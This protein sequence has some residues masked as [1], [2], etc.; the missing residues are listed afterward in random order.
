M[1]SNRNVAPEGFHTVTPHLVMQNAAEAIAFYQKLFGATET[2]RA[3]YPD[4]QKIMH[5][6]IE[7]GDSRI[8]L[9]D[10]MEG[11]G[12]RAPRGESST[13][14]HVYVPHVDKTFHDALR[15]GARS[16]MQPQD[17]FWGDRYCQILDPFGHR[18]SLATKIRTVVGPELE[19]GARQAFGTNGQARS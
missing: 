7:I 8:M 5:A 6:T 9:A 3:N 18:W 4:S 14:L 11:H 10:E 17:T 15:L 19:K 12:S 2:F 16:L 1:S 13:Y